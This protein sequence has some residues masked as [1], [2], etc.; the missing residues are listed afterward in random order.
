MIKYIL[1]EQV[2]PQDVA[3]QNKFL[4]VKIK[5]ETLTLRDFAKRISRE[6]TVSSMDTM[7]V[8]EGLLQIL[9]DEIANGKIIKLGDFGTFR[10]TIT[11]ETADT[12]E[13]FH[14]TQIKGLNVRFRP[15]K[16]FTKQISHIDFQMVS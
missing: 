12:K 13:A 6:S 5:Q 16:E 14:V 8:L 4:P 2:N 10:S 15:S 9:P 1:K 7:A 11:S 3:A